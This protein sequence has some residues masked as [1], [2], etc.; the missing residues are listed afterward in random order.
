MC[1]LTKKK[2]NDF[3]KKYAVSGWMKSLIHEIQLNLSGRSAEAWLEG[4][5]RALEFCE[6][7]TSYDQK[8]GQI[9]S[10]IL[11]VIISSVEDN[12]E[13]IEELLKKRASLDGVIKEAKIY[14]KAIDLNK[15]DLL[16]SAPERHA[17]AVEFP[18]IEDLIFDG[19]RLS[20]F[21][22]A[23]IMTTPN[24]PTFEALFR[25]GMGVYCGVARANPLVNSLYEDAAKAVFRAIKRPQALPV[26]EKPFRLPFSKKEL[27]FENTKKVLDWL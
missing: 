15:I 14:K 24:N 6:S 5:G 10:S 7:Y 11:G 21:E 2:Y 26:Y 13:E 18:E 3:G 20:C 16:K 22:A 12:L 8:R 4:A 25:A 1:H 19:L 17:R 9:T 23:K 27:A